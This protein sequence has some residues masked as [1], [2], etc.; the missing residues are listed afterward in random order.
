MGGYR[1]G[2]SIGRGT[3]MIHT[4]EASAR[5]IE[6]DALIVGVV[7]GPDG[8][9]PAPGA[10]DVDEARGAPLPALPT[11]LAATGRAEEATKLPT[12][13][14]LPAPVIAALALGQPGDG[15]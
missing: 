9:S 4:S 13:G 6:A 2:T 10:G 3:M 12:A 8:P 11:A 7:Q 1:S 14:K 5:A 15:D